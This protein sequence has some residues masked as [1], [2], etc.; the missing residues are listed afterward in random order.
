M[1]LIPFLFCSSSISVNV[2]LLAK[3]PLGFLKRLKRY[4]INSKK[5][6]LKESKIVSYLYIYNKFILNIKNVVITV[7]LSL[8]KCTPFKMPTLRFEGGLAEMLCSWSLLFPH[9]DW[10]F[11]PLLWTGYWSRQLVGMTIM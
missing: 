4:I 3:Q 5:S 7:T 9:L 2:A 11:S 6:I 8:A 1:L 10:C